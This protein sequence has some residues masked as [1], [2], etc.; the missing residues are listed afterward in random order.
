MLE[1][2]YT[3]NLGLFT[4]NISVFIVP[5][6]MFS[7]STNGEQPLGSSALVKYLVGLF[8]FYRLKFDRPSSISV[9]WLLRM[10][11]M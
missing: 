4:R 7:V 5:L 9:H 6:E 2:L 10:H 3:V 8:Y 1:L 11:S